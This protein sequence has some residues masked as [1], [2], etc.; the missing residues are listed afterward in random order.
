M[1]AKVWYQGNEYLGDYVK[2][3][4]NQ[5]EYLANNNFREVVKGS[6]T[7]LF[8]FYVPVLDKEI[9][10]QIHEFKF[11]VHEDPID[12]KKRSRILDKLKLS[13]FFNF[14]AEDETTS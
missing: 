12:F 1:Q 5:V 6:Y 14:E 4:F 13:K 9:T 3:I 2:T 11:I 8:V 7:T 10:C